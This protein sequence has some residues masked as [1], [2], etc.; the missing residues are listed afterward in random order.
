[1]SKAV[2]RP[3]G[4]EVEVNLILEN[5]DEEAFW[6]GVYTAFANRPDVAEIADQAVDDLRLRLHVEE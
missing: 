3:Q 1:M 6:K 5:R 4:C 2:K